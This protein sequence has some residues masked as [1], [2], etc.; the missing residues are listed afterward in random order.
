MTAAAFRVDRGSIGC[1]RIDH[2]GN[3]IVTGVL[4]RTGVFTY[5]HTDGSI[6]RENGMVYKPNEKIN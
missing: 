3:L 1:S 5:R 4:N 6:T 2:N